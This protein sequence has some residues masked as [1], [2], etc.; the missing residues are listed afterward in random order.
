L[1]NYYKDNASL[2]LVFMSTSV[3]TLVQ[4]QKYEHI[5]LSFVMLPRDVV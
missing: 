1:K 2:F 4:I 3:Y 5:L